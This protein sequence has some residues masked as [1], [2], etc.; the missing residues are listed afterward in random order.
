M[1]L[2]GR[3]PNVVGSDYI[4]ANYVNVSSNLNLGPIQ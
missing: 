4:N 3:D 1:I 2:K